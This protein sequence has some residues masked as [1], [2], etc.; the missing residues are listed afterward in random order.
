M[1]SSELRIHGGTGHL[2]IP[3]AAFA[4][5]IGA[6]CGSGTPT[7]PGLAE[8][9]SQLDGIT[10]RVA[11]SA[12]TVAPGDSIAFVVT[13]ENATDTLVQVGEQC[14]PA[15]DVVVTPSL[16]GSP[17]VLSSGRA[18]FTCELGPQHFVA[19]RTTRTVSLTWR[20]PG[21]RGDYSARAGLR[22]SDGLSN[23]SAVV[24]ITVR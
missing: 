4:A 19:S 24:R 8:S 22:R 20:A 7:D 2:R 10:V 14:G 3:L 15:V 17:S 11:P 23:L 18:V 12:A 13:I 9:R 6:A 1:S 16:S 21:Q 5:V